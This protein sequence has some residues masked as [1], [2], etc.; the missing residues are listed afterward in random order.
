MSPATPGSSNGSS[1]PKT[2]CIAKPA[3]EPPKTPRNSLATL[4]Q[5]PPIATP[6]HRA[7][8]PGNN[9]T[10]AKQGKVT[11]RREELRPDHPLASV[12]QREDAQEASRRRRHP[13]RQQ[14]RPKFLG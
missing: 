10:A 8:N 4:K 9:G 14:Q 13:P 1:T 12:E 11:K 5:I 7:R 2:F 3:P 6:A